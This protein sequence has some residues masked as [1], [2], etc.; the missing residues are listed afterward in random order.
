MRRM[1]QVLA[2][3]A[4]VAVM[5]VVSVSPALARRAPGGHPMPTTKV[6]DVHLDTAN[7]QNERGAHFEVRTQ[8]QIA[9]CWLVFP[10]SE[11]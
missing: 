9:L 4:L 3:A 7:A 1:I 2:V 5:L 11:E 10:V 8:S 6:C